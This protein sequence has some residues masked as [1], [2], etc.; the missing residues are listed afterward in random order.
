MRSAQSLKAFAPDSKLSGFCDVSFAPFFKDSRGF[1]AYRV[2]T[3]PGRENNREIICC[4][5]NPPINLSGELTQ[6]GDRLFSKL[7]DNESVEVMT[8]EDT[9]KVSKMMYNFITAIHDVQQG[10]S[11][12][13]ESHVDKN[14]M[15]ESIQHVEDVV[16]A[17]FKLLT[18]TNDTR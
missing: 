13:R 2:R 1:D 15:D 10:I 4:A 3:G 11:T 16:A 17:T 9:E 6:A 5:D 7:P 18:T 14:D 12:F 8:P